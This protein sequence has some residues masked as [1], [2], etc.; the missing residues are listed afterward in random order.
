[1]DFNTVG[2]ARIMT[3]NATLCYIKKENKVLMLHRIKKVNDIHEGKWNGLGGKI[4]QGETPEE[5]IIREVYEESGLKIESP[6][7]KG[8]ITFPLFDGENDWLVFVFLSDKFS[9]N[10][11]ESNEGK[12]EW[13]DKDKILALPLWEGDKIFLPWVFDETFFSAKFIYKN[14]KLIDWNVIKY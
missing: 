10:I 6:I 3:I 8:I 5:C 12:L 14:K 1:M 9:G 2:A 7:L 4:E 13:I 11:I